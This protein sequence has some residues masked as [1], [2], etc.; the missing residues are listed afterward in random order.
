MRLA[1][2]DGTIWSLHVDTDFGMPA[3]DRAVVSTLLVD[4][5]QVPASAYGLRMLTLVCNINTPSENTDA[6]ELQKLFRE[7]DR[8]YNYLRWQPDVSNPV[9]FRTFR[10]EV[11]QVYWDQMLKRVTA[12]VLAEPFAYGLREDVAVGVVTNDPAAATRGGFFDVAG[13]KGD[14]A[15]PLM[16]K[17]TT[18]GLHPFGV[19]ASRSRGTPSDL[20]WFVQGENSS[21]VLAYDFDTAVPAGGP[22][23]A[24]S[25]TG[26]QNYARTTFSTVATMLARIIWQ[27]S[28]STTTDAQKKAIRG[29][30][31]VFTIV[32]RSDNTSVMRVRIGW[33]PIWATGVT[34]YNPTV[35]LPLTTARQVVDMG[36][37]GVGPNEE[38]RPGRFG[39]EAPLLAQS[40][41]IEA[42]RA[43]GAG[44]LDW[45]L[46]LLI[47]A[48]ESFLTWWTKTN[49]GPASVD[50]LIDGATDAIYVIEDGA[51]PFAGTADI[52]PTMVAQL[53]GGF[54][55][56]KPSVTNRIYTLTATDIV[57]P[58]VSC[59]VASTY[60][61]TAHY[62]PRYLFVRPVAS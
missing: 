28:L 12:S 24:M 54:P 2:E 40:M 52:Q 41:R 5:G 55:M 30:Y 7:L 14:V 47:P 45:D 49:A 43:S 51:D 60:T 61:L 4:G 46:I 42:E 22:D 17:D 25:G 57:T 32:R 59:A 19:L 23:A 1:L 21:G 8:P 48:D 6:A 35:T 26:T 27:I 56:L 36:L 39:A 31:R 3:V 37:F 44:T 11:A 34:A 33:T 53:A 58:G 13:V 62:F 9:F 15:T 38:L 50:H 18:S 20:V 10:S 16:I 29:T